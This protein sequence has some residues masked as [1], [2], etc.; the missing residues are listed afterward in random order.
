MSLTNNIYFNKEIIISIVNDA[1]NKTPGIS[2][3][4]HIDK[5]TNDNGKTVIK[6]HAKVDKEYPNA[7]NVIEELQKN[8]YYRVC[9]ILKS[10]RV[11]IDIKV[12]K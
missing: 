1:V 12:D 7:L 11:K 5:P 9:N 4:S 8:V 6:I 10:K 2:S 3:G